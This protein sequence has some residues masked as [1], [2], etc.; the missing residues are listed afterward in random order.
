[1]SNSDLF[2]L[3]VIAIS[4]FLSVVIFTPIVVDVVNEFMERHDKKDGPRR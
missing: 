1:M 3:S 4:A 2:W